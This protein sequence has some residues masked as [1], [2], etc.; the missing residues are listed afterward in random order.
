MCA[1]RPRRVPPFAAVA[2]LV[3]RSV[4]LALLAAAGALT[5]I[6]A[7]PA[8]AASFRPCALSL[9][10]QDPPGGTSAYDLT[11]ERISVR[12][13]TA[14]TVMAAFH[15]CRAPVGSRCFRKVAG[16]WRC[17]G[18]R[19]SGTPV[20]AGSF[21]CRSGRRRVRSSYRQATP[22]CFGAAARDPRRRCVNPARSLG[23]PDDMS[24][25]C[26]PGAV[27]GACL[28]GHLG[29]ETRG[30]FA[31][32][33][34]SHVTH[35]RSALN[36]VAQSERWR[37]YSL[38]AGGCF[39][40]EAVGRFLEAC[41]GWYRATL[42]WFSQHPEVST[43]FVTSNADTPVAV[44]PGETSDGVKVDGFRRAWQALPRSVR[45]VVVLRD[46]T[47]STPETLL[48]LERAV[49]AGSRRLSTACPLA[50]SHALRPDLAVVAARRLRSERYAH[51]DLSD[52]LCAPSVCFP[53]VGGAQVNAD[54]WGHL[55]STFMTTL[56]PYLLR[57][58]RRLMAT[59]EPSPRPA[60]I[61][62]PRRAQPE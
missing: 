44:H 52:F 27:P 46:T 10:D 38:A 55:T 15:R 13:A 21:T 5:P 31:V 7:P 4:A 37:G 30:H 58:L 56:G 41:D 51:I 59:W 36:V 11:L 16:S 39:F 34:D 48:C 29:P 32:V 26:D 49:A 57:E 60:R 40:S 19:D 20:F 25:V 9:R 8:E 2:A 53:A 18:R 61:P 28:F 14:K 22:D 47:I 24:W 45:H 3:S 17:T 1:P 42:A 12:C 6:A 43:V 35:W 23:P 54:V 33:G 62:S 50:R